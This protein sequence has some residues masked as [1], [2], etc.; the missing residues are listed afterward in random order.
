MKNLV[1]LFLALAATPVLALDKVGVAV[2]VRTD[3]RAV[4]GNGKTEEQKRFLEIIVTNRTREELTDLSVKWVIFAT[5]LKSNDV[6][7]AGK[8]DVKA[9]VYP[10]RNEVITAQTVTMNYTPRHAERSSQS[11]GKGSNKKGGNTTSKT[12]EASGNRYK[13]WGVQVFQRGTMVGEAYST[14]ELKTRM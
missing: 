10:Q 7:K 5:D 13:G 3:G 11:K 1:P 8:G 9:S 12:V 14:H 2:N 6:T 4:D